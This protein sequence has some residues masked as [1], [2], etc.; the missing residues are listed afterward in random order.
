MQE[1]SEEFQ[2]RNQPLHCLINSAGVIDPP[3]D[4]T[5]EGFEVKH[6]CLVDTTCVTKN[7]KCLLQMYVWET[8][9]VCTYAGHKSETVCCP[10]FALVVQTYDSCFHSL[11][12]TTF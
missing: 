3:D 2:R 9:K 7:R 11:Y 5:P 10:M 1:C 6:L 4:S 12:I 8:V